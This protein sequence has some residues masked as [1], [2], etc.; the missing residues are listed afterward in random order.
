[1]GI[2]VKVAERL[3]VGLKRFQ[4]VL[5]SAKTRDVNE[6]DTSMI[7][8]D[9]LAEVFGY[10]KYHEI[11]REL[12]IRGTFCDLAT[13]IDGKVSM[14]VEVKAIGMELKDS[15]GRQAVDYAANAGIEWVVVTNGTTWR[16]VKV[17]FGKPIDQEL[18][19]ELSIPD[20]N[21]RSAD[22]IESLFLLTKESAVKSGLD[23]YSDHLEATNR[24]FLAALVLSDNVLEIVRRELRRVSS[25][26]KIEVEELRDSLIRD[27]IKRDVLEGDKA[28]HA[29]KKIAR[30]ATK[31]LRVKRS[32]EEEKSGDTLKLAASRPP[33]IPT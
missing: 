23:A 16:V 27:V 2:P 12:C 14:L 13:K 8:T 11:T 20:L 10:D 26:V 32:E 1:M 9:M 33:Q 6:S 17:I 4:P 7:V 22:D 24:F 31:L 25:D 5:T 30:A 3:A 21:P 15:H 18:V 19:L 29:K 28:D